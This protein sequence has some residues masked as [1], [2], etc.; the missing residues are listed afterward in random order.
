M[1]LIKTYAPS[2]KKYLIENCKNQK[3]INE[4]CT[5]L[6]ILFKFKNMDNSLIQNILYIYEKIVIKFNLSNSCYYQNKPLQRN[7]DIMTVQEKSNKQLMELLHEWYEEIR[8]Y[9]VVEAKQTYLKVKESLKEIE[10]DQY[11]SFYYSLLN[12]RYKVLVDGMS[13]TK[14]SFNQIEK[15][16]HIKDEF[17]F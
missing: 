15:L 11:V 10:T 7:G 14:D 5:T 6:P 3:Y 17:S 13:I 1:I 16:P 12:F 2:H 8:L 4:T 9:H